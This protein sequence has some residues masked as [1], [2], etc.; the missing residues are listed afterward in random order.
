M[1]RISSNHPSI[2]ITTSGLN[3]RLED[4]YSLLK[5]RESASV[6]E[7]RMLNNAIELLRKISHENPEVEEYYYSLGMLLY[8]LDTDFEL[9]EYTL[10]F[11]KRSI[12]MNSKRYSFSAG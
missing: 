6:A 8:Q 12:S 1:N 9:R 5:D 7:Q 2:E 11:F 3:N 10:E 4:L